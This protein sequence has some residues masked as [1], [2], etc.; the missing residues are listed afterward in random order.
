MSN[1][2]YPKI[3]EFLRNAM[4]GK[5]GVDRELAVELTKLIDETS[6]LASEN[7]MLRAEND[8][9]YK[10][11][12]VAREL[13]EEIAQSNSGYPKY[14][15]DF[16]VYGEDGMTH[17]PSDEEIQ[18]IVNELYDEELENG[19]FV[20]H[21]VG[22]TIVIK[23]KSDDLEE[24]IVAKGHASFIVPE[25]DDNECEFPDCTFPDFF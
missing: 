23:I 9:I 20:E 13:V 7:G 24:I 3:V 14:P 12:Q 17:S 8:A 21:A 22:D 11:L 19:Q 1:I 4:N 16:Y 6:K 2:Q 25:D 15:D 5:D 10:A 18:E